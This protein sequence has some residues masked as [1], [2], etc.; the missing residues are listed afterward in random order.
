[1]TSKVLTIDASS[2][3]VSHTI[4]RSVFKIIYKGRHRDDLLWCRLQVTQTT[5]AW[6][7]F[8]HSPQL[9]LHISV[10]LGDCSKHVLQDSLLDNLWGRFQDVE[11]VSIQ[12]GFKKTLLYILQDYEIFLQYAEVINSEAFLG[13]K[14]YSA[15]Q[16]R[17]YVDLVSGVDCADFDSWEVK[18]NFNSNV[19][20]KVWCLLF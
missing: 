17:L 14:A 3:M 7:V 1:M 18:G 20:P 5:N 9:V 2:R 4:W 8:K 15:Q 11:S 12:V 10:Q 19:S 16:N 13:A 6:G